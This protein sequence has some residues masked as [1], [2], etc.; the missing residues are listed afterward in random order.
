MQLSIVM[1]AM[2]GVPAP[3]QQ[4]ARAALR[5]AHLSLQNY[6]HRPP[7]YRDTGAVAKTA[8]ATC[9]PSQLTALA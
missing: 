3:L 4:Q 8:P 1:A 6:A 9:S 5:L 7:S 2:V